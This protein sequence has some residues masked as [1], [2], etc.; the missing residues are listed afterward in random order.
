MNRHHLMSLL[1][2]F[3][4]LI[5]SSTLVNQKKIIWSFRK[6]FWNKLIKEMLLVKNN[7]LKA[8][9]ILYQVTKKKMKLD[10]IKIII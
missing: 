8:A 9:R 1:I 3:L 4:K 10:K 5:H 6:N 2:K 7:Y